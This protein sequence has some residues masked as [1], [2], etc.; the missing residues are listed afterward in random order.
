[1]TPER[2]IS[3]ESQGEEEEQVGRA[4]RPTSLASFV[5]QDIQRHRLS[6]AIESARRRGET[7]DHVLLSGPPGIGKTSISHIIATEMGAPFI[8]TTGPAMDKI[9]DLL[10]MLT[11]LPA[12]AVLLIDEA[13]RLPHNVEE[14]LY[15][16]MEDFK[17]DLMM[18]G[19][20]DGG[21]R[22]TI[23]IDL[24]PFTLVAATTRKGMM[25]AP[26]RMRFGLDFELDFYVEDDLAKIV[27]R[28]A[29]LIGVAL[30]PDAAVEIARRSR[31]TPRITNRLLRRVRDYAVVHDT[32]ACD[33]E[34]V[35]KALRLEGVDSAGLD[36]LDRRYLRTLIVNYA[37]GP[38]GLRALAASMQQD[39]DTLEDAVEPFL[40]Y[41][42]YINRTVPGRRATRKAFEH[43]ANGHA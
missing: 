4:L 25:S 22:S 32:Q 29:S 5:G 34:L 36:D 12:G 21:G 20:P 30:A 35:I 40:L 38:A 13:H 27:T 43:M 18:G 14:V 42:G 8:S 41:Q 33:H 37:G 31:G 24:Q 23:T 11:T 28:S 2:I 6:I 16:A 10:G 15:S 7:L 19:G 1:M 39:A 17:V 9:A 3:P 26:L